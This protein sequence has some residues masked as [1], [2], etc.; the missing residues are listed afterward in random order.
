MTSTGLGE[1]ETQLL[2]GTNKVD[3]H[4][5]PRERSR[6]LKQTYLLVIKGL[7]WRR[8]LTGAY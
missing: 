5:D 7:L 2:E 6:R 3:M 4:Q 1:I 8:G